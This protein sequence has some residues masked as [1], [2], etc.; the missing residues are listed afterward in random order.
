MEFSRLL[1][2]FVLLI[3]RIGFFVSLFAY[4]SGQ[5]SVN[6]YSPTSFKTF[7]WLWVLWNSPHTLLH[8]NSVE[9]F[10]LHKETAQ[11]RAFKK[12]YPRKLALVCTRGTRDLKSLHKKKETISN[13]VLPS[14]R[15]YRKCDL[16]KSQNKLPR[17]ISG[18]GFK[19]ASYEQSSNW[20]RNVEVR[21]HKVFKVVWLIL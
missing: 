6:F 15:V 3:Y 16:N 2:E 7:R 11:L 14:M 13:A 10:W 19:Q 8:L 17:K 4:F 9:V 20:L 5:Q 18:T 1:N 12:S 21:K